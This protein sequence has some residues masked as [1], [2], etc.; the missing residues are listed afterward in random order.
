MSEAAAT[1]A[2]T[3]DGGDAGSLDQDERF[4]TPP[5][6]LEGTDGASRTEVDGASGKTD[7][8]DD[9]LDQAALKKLLAEDGEDG[10]SKDPGED[11]EDGLVEIELESGRKVRADPE[12]K[13]GY[14]RTK[15]YT[16]KTNEVAQRAAVL[17]TQAQ[18]IAARDA[19]LAVQSQL[20]EARHALV[21]KMAELTQLQLQID[22]LDNLNWP[23]LQTRA[24]LKAQEGDTTERDQLATLWTQ[25]A[26]LKA[27]RDTLQGEV[28]AAEGE[29]QTKVKE[30]AELATKNQTEAIQRGD[31]ELHRVIPKWGEQ[32]VEIL[33][34]GAQRFG[35]TGEEL[36][37]A[38]ADPRMIRVLH[39]ASE[40]LK[41][42]D[43]NKLLRKALRRLQGGAPAE[44][45]GGGR[46]GGAP[47]Q[48]TD[49]KSDKLTTAEWIKQERERGAK[50]SK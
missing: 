36:I 35:F 19:E 48:T 38:V 8:D 30:A 11:S 47:V 3:P 14:E 32:R 6:G 9:D 24:E 25:R 17:E 45:V 28:T 2:T 40:G 31:A 50:K 13:A 7:D 29:V 5:T 4:H 46:Q 18:A 1:A 39:E 16:A 49:P 21:P 41:A 33:R 44:T 42:R 27:K 12:L 37:N 26:E 20:Y 34:F 22:H 23:A 10:T 15:D 43:Q